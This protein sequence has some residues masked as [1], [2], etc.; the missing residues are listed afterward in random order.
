[1]IKVHT[2]PAQLLQLLAEFEP[3][4]DLVSSLAA[5]NPSGR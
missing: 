3:P 5:E 1:M 4:I 2:N